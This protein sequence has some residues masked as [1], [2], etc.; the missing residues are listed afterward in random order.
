MAGTAVDAIA[1][2]VTRTVAAGP[3][4]VALESVSDSQAWLDRPEPRPARRPGA[5]GAAGRVFD[6]GLEFGLRRALRYGDLPRR[7]DG[8]LDLEARRCAIDWG[9]YAETIDGSREWSG[10]S[11]RS[12]S[13]L[14]DEPARAPNPL[15]LFDLLRGVTE[16]REVGSEIVGGRTCRHLRASADMGRVAEE[17]PDLTALPLGFAYEELGAIPVEVWLDDAGLVRR[18][19]FEAR[20]IGA[21]TQVHSLELSDFGTRQSSDPSRLPLLKDPRTGVPT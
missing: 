20:L 3:A 13:T 8:F 19:D 16:A 5:A 6:K 14:P 4:K 12:L 9:A 15:W 11:G 2:A 21:A 10:R 7:A 17:T 18:I 1:D